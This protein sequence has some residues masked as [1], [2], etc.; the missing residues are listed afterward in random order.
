MAAKKKS[1]KKAAKKTAK[2]KTVKAV[3]SAARDLHEEMTEFRKLPRY[4][5]SWIELAQSRIAYMTSEVERLKIENRDLKA[6]RKFA[7]HRI[8][9]S[10]AE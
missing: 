2:S 4:W 8:L 9:R 7:E 5:R 10:E 6:Y 1:P 3:E